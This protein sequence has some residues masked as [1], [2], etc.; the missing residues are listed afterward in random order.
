M[1][2]TKKIIVFLLVVIS[3]VVNGCKKE[4][5]Q[6]PA[7]NANVKSATFS[8]STWYWNTPNYYVNL[9]VTELTS[10]NVNTAAVMVYFTYGNKPW[11]AVPYSQYNYPSNYYMGF[12]TGVGNVQVT[13]FY[14][15]SLSSGDDPN[16]YYA[17]TIKIKV[18]TIPPAEIKKHPDLNLKNYQ[19]VSKTFN[20]KD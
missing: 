13:W 5:A 19:E 1:K 14:D 3:V 16:T 8:V 18:V 20:L 15:S 9:G 2:K 10:S 11:Y 7:G 12:N 4:G 6:G 17:A